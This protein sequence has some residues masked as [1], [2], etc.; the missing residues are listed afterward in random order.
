MNSNKLIF[1]TIILII[2]L[3]LKNNYIIQQCVDLISPKTKP[4]KYL[5]SVSAI[6]SQY[7]SFLKIYDNC[8]ANNGQ[9]ISKNCINNL[10]KQISI[11]SISL[12]A[13][14]Y[15][16][17]QF[18]KVGNLHKLESLY[19]EENLYNAFKND[20]K[21]VQFGDAKAL[22]LTNG[23][24][25]NNGTEFIINVD[26]FNKQDNNDSDENSIGISYTPNFKQDYD[27]GKVGLLLL[28]IDDFN[29]RFNSLIPMTLIE[30]HNNGTWIISTMKEMDKN[31]NSNPSFSS[32]ENLKWYIKNDEK[33][34]NRKS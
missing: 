20:Y 32:K 27:L 19:K 29:S 8:W 3:C 18:H 17:K 25:N 9:F 21:S 11:W 13:L 24:E 14:D 26:S 28:G 31:D 30:A 2:L 1:I 16:N 22:V 15:F 23:I 7:E 12:V 34:I 4:Q 33:Y 6:A 10:S 5:L